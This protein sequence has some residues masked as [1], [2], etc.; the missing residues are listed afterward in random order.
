MKGTPRRWQCWP[1][2]PGQRLFLDTPLH[3][4]EISCG[5]VMMVVKGG[6]GETHPRGRLQNL[7]EC[8]PRTVHAIQWQPGK[9]GGPCWSRSALKQTCPL[10]QD[11]RE[12]RDTGGAVPKLHCPSSWDRPTY[13]SLPKT[14]LLVPS[15]SLVPPLLASWLLCVHLSCPGLQFTHLSLSL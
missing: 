3:W 8:V 11:P 12:V 9:D 5:L 6:V 15:P 10:S 14:D 4:P 1:S 2:E 7:P 13:P